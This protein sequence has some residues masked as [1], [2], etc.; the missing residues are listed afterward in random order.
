MS[1][2]EKTGSAEAG[3]DEERIAVWPWV[4]P[5]RGGTGGVDRSRDRVWLVPSQVS[6]VEVEGH[7]LRLR[8]VT[9]EVYA[10]RGTLKSLEQRWAAYGF[11]RI[12]NWYLVFLPHVQQA[13]R[14]LSDSWEVY[15]SS[16]GRYFP[17]SRRRWSK[18]KQELEKHGYL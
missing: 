12:H 7:L 6:W 15:L 17:V 16:G 8:T 10:R 18:V 2:S 9:G 11:V 14:T 4:D 13:V 1:Q 3:G 5:K